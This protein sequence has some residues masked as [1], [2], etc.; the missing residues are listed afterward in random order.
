MNK[1]AVIPAFVK[2]HKKTII[3]QSLITVGATAGLILASGALSK[4]IDDE[5]D[6][7][8]VEETDLENPE[9]PNV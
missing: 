8:V 7:I 3:T 5:I 1:L 2:A 9:I 4:K 6:V